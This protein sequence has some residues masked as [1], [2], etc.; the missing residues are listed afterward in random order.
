MN[1]REAVRRVACIV[2]ALATFSKTHRAQP[3]PVDFDREHTAHAYGNL[4]PG[5]EI[6]VGPFNTGPGVVFRQPFRYESAVRFHVVVAAPPATGT[7]SMSVTDGANVVWQT[8]SA[9]EVGP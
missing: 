3:A 6:P 8:T 2:V 1:K 5:D 9:A 4:R 7:W